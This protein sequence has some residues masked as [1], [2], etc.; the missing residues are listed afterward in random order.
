MTCS[1]QTTPL[2]EPLRRVGWG[3]SGLLVHEER[4]ALTA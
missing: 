3:L 2:R 1:A 4:G